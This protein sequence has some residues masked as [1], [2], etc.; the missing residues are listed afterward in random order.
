MTKKAPRLTAIKALE[1][2]ALTPSR[3]L[4]SFSLVVTALDAMYPGECEKVL[5]QAAL[6]FGYELHKNGTRV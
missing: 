3:L 5:K 6:W 1:R 2:K 4:Q